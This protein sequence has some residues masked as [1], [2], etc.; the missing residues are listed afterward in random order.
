MAH[1]DFLHLYALGGIVTEEELIRKVHGLCNG[2]RDAPE[3]CEAIFGHSKSRSRKESQEWNRVCKA[4]DHLIESG[5]LYMKDS[6]VL[7]DLW[8]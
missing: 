3:I 4:I 1:L 5:D 2:T 6:G 8:R 7:L